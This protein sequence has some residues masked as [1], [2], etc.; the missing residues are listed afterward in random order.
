MT[1]HICFRLNSCA[2]LGS[3]QKQNL[4]YSLE[5]SSDSAF[6]SHSTRAFL[7]YWAL[8]STTN[9]C[10]VEPAKPVSTDL[11]VSHRFS[12]GF[13]IRYTAA[14]TIGEERCRRRKSS[15]QD[16]EFDMWLNLKRGKLLEVD[17]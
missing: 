2:S 15:I 16:P 17:F 8:I 6:I 14:D 1:S 5:S 7:L 10:F 3:E 12:V 9:P 11:H 13:G 4:L